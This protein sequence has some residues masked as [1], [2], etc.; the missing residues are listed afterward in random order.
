MGAGANRKGQAMRN[1]KAL[2]AGTILLGAICGCP[3]TFSL[4]IYN[5]S[6]SSIVGLYIV[7]AESS[8]WGENILDEPILPGGY[9]L[10]YNIAPG[11]YDLAAVMANGQEFF[12][13]NQCYGAGETPYW[14]FFDTKSA[15]ERDDDVTESIGW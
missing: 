11:C 2:L 7:P 3:G 14:R 10:V 4:D 15:G 6:S 8:C 13:F 9:F 12:H 5:D 1:A